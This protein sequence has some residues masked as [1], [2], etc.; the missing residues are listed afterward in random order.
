MITVHLSI[1]DQPTDLAGLMDPKLL[2][3]RRYS[4]TVPPTPGLDRV[5]LYPHDVAI[6]DD[7]V[8]AGVYSRVLDFVGVWHVHL[9]TQVLRP[10]GD[11][12]RH[13]RGEDYDSAVRPARWEVQHDHEHFLNLL[14]HHGWTML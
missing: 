12:H 1:V 3:V 6:S 2:L 8:M 14:G 4:T 10:S 13:L 7:G 5:C 9:A 11:A